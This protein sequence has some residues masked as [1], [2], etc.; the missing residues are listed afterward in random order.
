[1]KF[2]KPIDPKFVSHSL[3]NM[4]NCSTKDFIE[5]E[6]VKLMTILKKNQISKSDFILK[7][8]IEGSEIAVIK[9]IIDGSMRPKQILV[10]FDVMRNNHLINFQIVL[11]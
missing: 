7:L 11:R 9:N 2:Y 6:S 10:E 1:M 5:V 4:H 3:T 8:D